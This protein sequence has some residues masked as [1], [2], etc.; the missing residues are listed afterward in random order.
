MLL[1]LKQLADSSEA[2]SEISKMIGDKTNEW[3]NALSFDQKRK[4][5]EDKLDGIVEELLKINKGSIEWKSKKPKGQKI[6][7]NEA[8]EGYI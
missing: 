6:K 4:L 5:K 1:Q 7:K 2:G 3:Y 8:I